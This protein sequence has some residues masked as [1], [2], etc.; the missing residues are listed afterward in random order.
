MNNTD[1]AVP[2]GPGQL[3]E[4]GFIVP[5]LFQSAGERGSY[6]FIEF[7]TSNI[8]NL[9][10]RR[11]YHRA[12]LEFAAWCE[13]GGIYSLD[14]V[15]SIHVAAFR[16][17]RL[18]GTWHPQPGPD[19]RRWAM[20]RPTVKQQL[21]AIRMLFDYLLVGQAM[22]TNPAAAV[23]GPKH[24]VAVGSTPIIS[25]E[26]ARQLF[27][28]IGDATPI[29]LR[30]RALVAAMT[31]SFARIS[32]MLNCRIRDYYYESQR[33]HR[34]WLRL[35]EKGSKQTKMPLHHL[36]H[37]YLDAYV[38]GAC[39]DC[40]PDDWLFRASESKLRSDIPLRKSQL[41]KRPISQSDAWNMLQR[42]AKKAGL[43]THIT[44]HTFRATG[45]T[46]Y[47]RNGGKLEIAQK[48]A[49]HESARTTGLYDRR[50]DELSLDEI[51]RIV[52]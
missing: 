40:D 41:S 32:A 43:M 35:Y 30:D 31:F 36:L 16:E 51:E 8:E 7:F 48:M 21:A 9:H 14:D 18:Q 12:A 11:A 46:E 1:L 49:N 28:S 19:P 25:A 27:D 29:A 24:S 45:I 44:N 17:A 4:V 39:Q 20:S 38:K 50:G 3:V 22:K 13:A 42:R 5:A 15:Q 2:A 10:T 6:R 52:I 33:G 34:A 23:R 26:E 47:L 37:D